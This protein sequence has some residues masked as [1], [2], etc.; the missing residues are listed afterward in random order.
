MGIE[1][2][3][4]D[5]SNRQPQMNDVET[6][7]QQSTLVMPTINYVKPFPNVLKIEVFNGQNF[8][9]WY[10]HVHSIL[11]MD[12]VASAISEVKPVS[13]ATQKII[14]QWTHGNKIFNSNLKDS[15]AIRD[16]SNDDSNRRPQINDVGT[17][18]QQPAVLVP[19]INYAKS[20]P[21]V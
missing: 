17:I 21:D 12:G 13:S 1:D 8:C 15:M 16:N 9:R 14:D 19:T 2:N 6:I 10:E 3:S 4:S 20:F 11:D 18:Q 5:D 7:Q